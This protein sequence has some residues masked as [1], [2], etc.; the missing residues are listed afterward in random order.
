MIGAIDI[1]GT[2]IAVAMVAPAGRVI[3]RDSFATQAES[4]PD[5]AVRRIAE[6]L[7]RWRSEAGTPLEGIGIG[8]TGPVDP[9]AGRVLDVDLLPGWNGFPSW[10]YQV[11]NSPIWT[12]SPIVSSTGPGP[13]C[14]R[15]SATHRSRRDRDRARADALL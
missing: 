15:R 8:C 1:G 4:S 7:D 14:R 9:I 3:A 5:R 13:G 11:F 2:K 6:L 10:S 12:Y